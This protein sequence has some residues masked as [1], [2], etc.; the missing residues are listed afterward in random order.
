MVRYADKTHS[1]GSCFYY[2]FKEDLG[3]AEEVSGSKHGWYC[4]Q[5]KFE[6]TNSAFQLLARTGCGS[7]MEKS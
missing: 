7:W 2:D 5:A 1:C 4:N 6:I 3:R